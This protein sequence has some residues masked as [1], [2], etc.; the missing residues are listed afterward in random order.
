MQTLITILVKIETMHIK[1][2]IHSHRKCLSN[3]KRMIVWREW[4]GT[5]GVFIGVASVIGHTPLCDSYR[6]TAIVT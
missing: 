6:S 3:A 2:V 1:K 4:S 5:V